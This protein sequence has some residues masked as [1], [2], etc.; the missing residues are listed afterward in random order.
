MAKSVHSRER[1]VGVI[2]GLGPE[3][4]VDFFER[5]L[6]NTEAESDQDHLHLLIDNNPKV[7]NRNHAIAGTGPSP[8]DA[9]VSSAVRLENAG[10]EFLV[11]P[12]NTAHA[13]QE[14]ITSAVSIPFISIVEETCRHVKECCPKLRSAGLLAVDGC[15]EAGLYRKALGK[16]N[17]QQRVLPVHRQRE[18]MELVYQIKSAGVDPG[19]RDAMRSLADQLVQQGCEAIVAGCTEVPLAL[20]PA[21]VPVPFMDSTEILAKR[22][23][24]YAKRQDDR[25]Q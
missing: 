7:P 1:V 6:R 9:L 24:R 17:I 3:A 13:F 21:Q 10:A 16:R 22:T 2:G 11:M 15:L 18:F 20:S 23:V 25:E 4:T 8:V 14:S 19:V 12:C 5:V